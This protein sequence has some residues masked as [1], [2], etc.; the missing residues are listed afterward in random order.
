MISDLRSKGNL[1]W[2]NIHIMIFINFQMFA[3]FGCKTAQTYNDFYRE[4][5]NW[6][7]SRDVYVY[8]N[9]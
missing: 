6:Y 9:M 5:V 7:S 3:N 2:L 1:T 8:I 4:D